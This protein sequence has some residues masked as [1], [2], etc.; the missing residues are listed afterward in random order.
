MKVRTKTQ[1]A[2]GGRPK[3]EQLNAG[4]AQPI[5]QKAARKAGRPREL[6]I[7]QEVE[8]LMPKG[9]SQKAGP[10]GSAAEKAAPAA[11][12]AISNASLAFPSSPLSSNP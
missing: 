8:R 6:S 4:P 2:E 1:K 12:T 10:Q 11:E 3:A 5:K 7:E 9:V